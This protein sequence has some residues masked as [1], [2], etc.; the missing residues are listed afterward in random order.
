MAVCFFL[1]FG[2]SAFAVVWG[3]TADKNFYS[4]GAADPWN[5]P[6]YCGLRLLWREPPWGQERSQN[7]WYC[8]LV[9]DKEEMDQL[10]NHYLMDHRGTGQPHPGWQQTALSIPAASRGTCEEYGTST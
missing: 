5:G 9:R 2:C 10:S 7:D 1:Y 3:A 4:G 8:T 6:E